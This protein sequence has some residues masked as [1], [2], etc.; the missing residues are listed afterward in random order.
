VILS[1]TA[2]M[3][4]SSNR[5]FH[6]IVKWFN[7]YAE[8]IEAVN[9]HYVLTPVGETPDWSLSRATRYMPLVDRS[10]RMKE[11]RLPISISDSQGQESSRYA[12]HYYFEIWQGGDRKYSP[13]YSE[14][15]A[16]GSIDQPSVKLDQPGD[17]AERS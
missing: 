12:L 9:I 4:V 11:L 14:E 15:V 6:R 16:T 5:T 10:L 2:Q 17:E 8:D 1:T 3:S 7:D 13:L